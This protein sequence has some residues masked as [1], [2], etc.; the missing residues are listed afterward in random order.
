MNDHQGQPDLYHSLDHSSGVSRAPQIMHRSCTSCVHGMLTSAF[1]R[2]NAT[3][4]DGLW[5]RQNACIGALSARTRAGTLPERTRRKNR[6]QKAEHD[7]ARCVWQ[8]SPNEWST[9]RAAANQSKTR[10]CRSAPRTS[11]SSADIEADRKV[12]SARGKSARMST[13]LCLCE[14]ILHCACVRDYRMRVPVRRGHARAAPKTAERVQDSA[15][16]E[17]CSPVASEKNVCAHLSTHGH[18]RCPFTR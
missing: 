3:I 7:P 15:S 11:S 8:S 2:L 9:G 13:Q 18:I 17:L 1:F 14:A 16:K 12:E 10:G 4:C 6:A 5:R